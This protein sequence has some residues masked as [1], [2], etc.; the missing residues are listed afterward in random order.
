MKFKSILVL[1]LIKFFLIRAKLVLQETNSITRSNVCNHKENGLDLLKNLKS[2]ILI[3]KNESLKVDKLE[4][5]LA[6]KIA[7]N[8][9]K[10]N[11]MIIPENRNLF[12]HT[13]PILAFKAGHN[14]K[15]SNITSTGSIACS[16]EKIAYEK[17]TL[18]VPVCPWHWLTAI[19][20]DRF[21]FKRSNAKCNCANCQAKTIYDSDTFKLSGCQTESVLMPV[22]FRETVVN[23]TEKWTFY[24]EEV[25]VACVCALKLNPY[26]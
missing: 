8:S 25:P 21:P 22:L 13:I 5:F 3:H 1:V 6:G 26:F 4:Q 2:F 7:T 10:I 16:L 9:E 18:P 19:R 17:N 11:S 12:Q 20:D 15:H 24:L 23:D 14:R